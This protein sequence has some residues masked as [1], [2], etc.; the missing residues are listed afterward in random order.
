MTKKEDGDV[1]N[2]SRYSGQLKGIFTTVIKLTTASGF[3]KD[4]YWLLKRKLFSWY[5]CSS[6]PAVQRKEAGHLLYFLPD[7]FYLFLFPIPFL[8][9]SFILSGFFLLQVML[10]QL[11]W[12]S[13]FHSSF[14][15]FQSR[16]QSAFWLHIKNW[17]I[18]FMTQKGLW[19]NDIWK[20]MTGNYLM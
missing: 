15:T 18:K 7:W 2:V 3:F 1:H 11:G 5:I 13:D 9:L 12:D 19:Y 4:S 14:S 16:A 6:T 17:G 10:R 20:L 8:S